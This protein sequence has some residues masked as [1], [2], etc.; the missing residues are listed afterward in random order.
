MSGIGLKIVG[1]K[2]GGRQDLKSGVQLT[3]NAPML[4]SYFWQM[5]HGDVRH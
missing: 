4:I 1:I 2:S 3:L 5:Y